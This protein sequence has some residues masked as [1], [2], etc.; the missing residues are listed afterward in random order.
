[1]NSN[2]QITYPADDD[3]RLQATAR[4]SVDWKNP[5]SGQAVPNGTRITVS[6]VIQIKKKEATHDSSTECYSVITKLIGK[7]IS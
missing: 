5:W 1:M 4:I 3:W 7:R 6:S 2:T